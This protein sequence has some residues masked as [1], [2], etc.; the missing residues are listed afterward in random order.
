MTGAEARARRILVVAGEA[1]GDRHAGGLVREALAQDS[2]LRF[3]GIGGEHLRA[4]GGVVLRD[5]RDLAVI[6]VAEV[7]A[8]APQLLRALREMRRRIRTERPDGLLLIDFPDF[9]LHLAGVAARCG[10]PVIYFVSPQLWAWR[11]GRVRKI[12][13]RVVRM[14]VLFAF[15]EEFYRRRGVPVTFAGHPLADQRPST[16]TPGEARRALGLDGEAPVYALLPGSRGA[17][18]SRLLPPLLLTARD[19]LA[20][21]PEAKFL[22]PVAETVDAA[23]VADAVAASGLPVVALSGAFDRIAAA[24][25]A[26]VAASGTVTLELAHRGVPAVVVYKTSLLSYWIGRLAIRVPYVSLVNLIAGREVLPELLQDDFTPS[27]A[28]TALLALGAP[29]ETRDAALRGLAEVRGRLGPPGAY[30]RAAAA[31][32]QALDGA[33][34]GAENRSP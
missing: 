34:P 11:Q 4:A 22:I 31:L 13:R 12:R 18:V 29:G 5:M 7:W 9:N 19:V 14:I 17:E 28:A 20:R 24:S 1:S 23:A 26:A 6:G 33:R 16:M 2:A 10:V 27:R 15:E 32:I 8:Q 3:A 25:D 21:R 30:R